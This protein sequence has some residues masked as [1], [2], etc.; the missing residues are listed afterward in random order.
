M[1]FLLCSICSSRLKLWGCRLVWA[2]ENPPA[3]VSHILTEGKTIADLAVPSKTSSRIAI[4]L[5][6]AKQLKKQ[7]PDIALYGLITGPFTLALHLLG[8]DIFMKMMEA[9]EEINELMSFTKEVG[10]AMATY[11]IDSVAM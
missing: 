8:T 7:Y 6:A 11:Y 5:D 10:K 1:A 2:D 3:V 9:P 4:A